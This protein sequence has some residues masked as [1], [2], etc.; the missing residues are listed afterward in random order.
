MCTWIVGKSTYDKS[1]EES[2]ELRVCT[3]VAPSLRSLSVST[4]QV[5]SHYKVSPLELRSYV[6]NM[7]QDIRLP[8]EPLFYTFVISLFTI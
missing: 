8:E 6:S 7:T 5:T 2:F 4:L 3:P 1:V